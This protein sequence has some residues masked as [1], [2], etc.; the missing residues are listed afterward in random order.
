LIGSS[1]GKNQIGT[2]GGEKQIG[3]GVGKKHQGTSGGTT[4]P[5]KTL[6][7]GQWQMIRCGRSAEPGTSKDRV[8]WKTYTSV[9]WASERDEKP[10][11]KQT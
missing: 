11:R 7:K 4:T 1:R 2:S 5:A 9:G 3:T 6:E 10:R 8:V